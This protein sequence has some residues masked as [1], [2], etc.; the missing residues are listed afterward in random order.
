MCIYYLS[1]DQKKYKVHWMAMNQRCF[2]TTSRR[3]CFLLHC[4]QISPLL[5]NRTVLSCPHRA[6]PKL[7]KRKRRY[8]KHSGIKRIQNIFQ[9]VWGKL[10][11]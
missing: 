7:M 10:Q 1:F 3:S 8:K 2:L 5:V 4:L 11:D 9:V 6:K